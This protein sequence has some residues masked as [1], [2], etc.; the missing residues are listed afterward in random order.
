MLAEHAAE[1]NK[2]SEERQ[3]RNPSAPCTFYKRKDIE[4]KKS[5]FKKIMETRNKELSKLPFKLFGR[6]HQIKFLI[7]IVELLLQ[8]DIRRRKCLDEGV[9]YQFTGI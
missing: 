8:E 1:L 5:L 9:A 7:Y 6:F 2:K 4:V 3:K